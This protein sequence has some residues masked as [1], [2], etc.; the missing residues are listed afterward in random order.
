MPTKDEITKTDIREGL[1]KNEFYPF[2]HQISREGNVVGAEVLA[3]WNSDKYGSTLSPYYFIDMI[4]EDFELSKIFATC[5]YKNT[6]EALGRMSEAGYTGYLSFNL[7]ASDLSPESILPGFIIGK[8]PK[9]L[10]ERIHLEVTSQ[11]AI[12]DEHHEVSSSRVAT[13]KDHG[14]IITIDDMGSARG[15]N[16]FDLLKDYVTEVKIDKSFVD[17]IADE[18]G[19]ELERPVSALKGIISAVRTM[20]TNDIHFILEG[21]ESGARG[22]TQM[23]VIQREYLG[24][25]SIQGFIFGEPVSEEDFINKVVK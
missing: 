2:F 16:V 24:F 15:F 7:S 22:R 9:E 5:M 14:F 8:T 3:R 4:N 23:E 13:L 6:I 21:V 17:T 11:H 20:S 25:A 18:S 10:V 1:E 19:N 12:R